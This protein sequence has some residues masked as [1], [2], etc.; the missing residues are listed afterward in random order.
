MSWKK[1][2]PFFIWQSIK[3]FKSPSQFI[4]NWSYYSRWVDSF[5]Q[6]RNS[7]SD[8]LP[9]LNYPAI[10]FLRQINLSKYK[11]FEYGGGGSTLFFCKSAAH[12]STVEDH[13]GW[14]QTLS[15]T[16]NQKGYT[17][18]EGHFRKPE[19]YKGKKIRSKENPDDF[20]SGGKGREN[21]TFE[22]YVKVIEGYQPEY[23]D[24]I[25]VDGRA[26]PSCIKLAI[27]HLKQGGYLIIDN[28]ERNYYLTYFKKFLAKQFIQELRTTA[29]VN[30]TPDF[31]QTTILRKL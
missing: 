29:P 25:L 18:W 4:Q 7:V 31:T 27:P 22:N 16:I 26:R 14:F 11:V 28:T 8:E 12:V 13:E 24:I 17:K 1:S 9:W 15:E 2:L 21:Y 3:Y 10:E 23:F 6:G 5:K 20:M 19:I 30:Y